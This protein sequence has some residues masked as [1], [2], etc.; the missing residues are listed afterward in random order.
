LN[1]GLEAVQQLKREGRIGSVGF[2]IYPMDLW[3]RIFKD[4]DID[5]ALIHNHHCLNDTRLL[6]LLPLAKQKNIGVINASPFACGL[7][8]DQGPPDW[9]PVSAADK[10][11][12]REVADFCRQQGTSISK[13]ALQFSTQNPDIPTTLFSTASQETVRRN[14]QWHEEP[15]DLALLSKVRALLKPVLN[16]QWEY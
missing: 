11:L 16:K 2:G 9:H 8:T 12:Y 4:H 5:A 3:H 13:L 15:C 10:P 1:G 7:L 6:E 14:V